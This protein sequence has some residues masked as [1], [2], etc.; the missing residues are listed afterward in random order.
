[1]MTYC[2]YA[3]KKGKAYR[4]VLW[5]IGFTFFVSG[6]ASAQNKKK[7]TAEND[8]LKMALN[9]QDSL[10]HRAKKSDTSI[11]SLLDKIEY[12]TASYNQINGVLSKGIDTN[13]ISD[14]LPRMERGIRIVRETVNN[15]D[16]SSTLRYLYA[17]RDILT[18]IEDRLEDWQD[19]LSQRNARL[20]KT[21]A[22]ISEFKRDP[23]LNFIPSESILQKQYLQQLSN[24]NS[25]FAKLE[26][27]NRTKLLNLGLLQNRVVQNYIRVNDYKNQINDILNKF[28]ER[29]ISKEYPYIWQAK[30]ADYP[31][32]FAVAW[33]AT[34]AM[35]HRLLSYFIISNWT[36][37]LSGILF[38]AAFFYWVY[39]SLKKIRESN[40]ESGIILKKAD[41]VP[42]HPFIS[43]LLVASII[44]LF[45]YDHP[46]AIFVEIIMFVMLVCTGILIKTF[47][48]KN[49]YQYWLPVIVLT[50]VYDVSN[51]FIKV[52]YAD[53]ITV[54]ILSVSC[55]IIG[56]S[57]MKSLKKSG[58]VLPGAYFL[59]LR[60]F[61]A[62][63]LI[64]L[65][66]NF[67]GRFSIAKM[68]GYTA[69]SGL[70]ETV[71]LYVFVRIV[72][73]AIFL[74]LESGKTSDETPSY[75]DY[76]TL[77]T[78]MQNVLNVVA[79]IFWL[80]WVAQNFN[81]I[82]FLVDL[83][84]GL[85]SQEH[86]IGDT[87]FTFGNVLLFIIIIWIAS[88][89]SKTITY[90]FEFADQHAVSATRKNKLSSSIL[91]VKLSIFG[92]G[93]LLAIIASSVPIE[94]IN[95]IIGALSV[96]IGFGLQTIVNNL[97]SGVILAF[98]KPVQI[99]DIIEVGGHSGAIREMGIRA[100]KIA[101][102]D[103]S[104]IIIPNGDLLSQH[105]INWTLSNNN[106]RVE[107]I[108]GVAYGSELDKV[109]KLLYH[110]V[111]DREYIMKTP[112]P[113]VLI[114]NF[115]DN[116]VDFRILFWV[117]DLTKWLEL[118]SR[119]MSDIYETFY[120]E[121]IEIPFPQRDVHLY[122]PEGKPEK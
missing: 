64:S 107:L 71:S 94:K 85:L 58:L 57:F 4:C 8:S 81:I 53:R 21:Q 11:N 79:V 92:S 41:F 65:L 45:F 2:F 106:R 121:K 111:M 100:S 22:R 120:L 75:F 27:I 14:G 36:I 122:Y 78:R 9:Y 63:Q 82:D 54:S 67:A 90:F 46:P 87:K 55:L 77:K 44:T 80:I 74:Q 72:M 86:T 16:K 49:L 29:S 110:L 116:S 99:G 115:S 70:W 119:L 56:F 61:M 6:F 113:M 95:I 24:L 105:L 28:A 23:T 66:L 117:E 25:K 69:L 51:L 13:T 42:A 84:T 62:M 93:F 20:V 18:R 34:V 118:K 17:V 39:R 15:N 109:R 104:E 33:A 97:V 50:S 43:S 30:P 83:S 3:H 114:H 5:L 19:K 48:P 7:V 59:L 52:S 32:S 91:L 26:S 37:H 10:L 98:E 112:A 12:Y 96:G 102:A 68:L 60:V 47:W 1:M 76:A 73:E 89:L 108:V 88:A 35:N 38:L 31:N 103:G 40:T 101:T